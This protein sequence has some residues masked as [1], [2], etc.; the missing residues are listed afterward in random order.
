MPEKPCTVVPSP[1]A[2]RPAALRKLHDALPGDLQAGL[3]QALH[4]TGVADAAAWDGLLIAPTSSA[5][6]AASVHEADPAAIAAVAW[7]QRLPGDTACLWIPPVND[8]AGLAVMRAAAAFVDERHIPLTQL[9]ASPDDGY[10]DADCELA[11]FPRFTTL[12]YLY[13]DLTGDALPVGAHRQPSAPNGLHFAGDA[14]R[15][16]VRLQQLIEQTYVGTLDCPQLDGVRP[17][18]EVLEGYRSQGTHRPEHWYLAQAEGLDVGVLI[19]AEHPGLGNWEVVYM[20]VA[21]AAR[22]RGYGSAIVEFA[23][24]VAASRHAERLVLAVDAANEP[25]L[26]MYRALGFITWGERVVYA[27]LRARA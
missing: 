14:E 10:A 19:L 13:V 23:M 21:A 26:Q 24:S 2:W 15:E 27:R 12:R 1:P 16:A 9:V 3:A 22:G 8:A 17:L 5:A 18:A 6:L 4:A 7:V 11:G 25:A 20:G